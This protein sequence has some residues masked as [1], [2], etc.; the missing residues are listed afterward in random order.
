AA[1]QFAVGLLQVAQGNVVHD[2]QQR[3]GIGRPEPHVLGQFV[4]PHGRTGSRNCGRRSLASPLLAGSPASFL[5]PIRPFPSSSRN[6]F[7][8]PVLRMSS[9][10]LGS[11]A[12]GG[13]GKLKAGGGGGFVRFVGDEVNRRATVIMATNTAQ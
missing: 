12:G 5:K 1:Q 3:I 2:S 8:F 11:R 13:F 4:F 9:K 10:A 6:S 7:R